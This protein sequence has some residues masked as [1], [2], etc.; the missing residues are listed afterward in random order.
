MTQPLLK[1]F[2]IDQTRMN[3]W[4]S[5]KN[6][7]SSELQLCLQLMN[8]VTL[9]EQAYYDL[10]SAK[11]NVRVQE[12]ALELANRLLAEN[13][14]RVEVG[15]MAPLDEKQAESRVA[16]TRAQLLMAQQ[17]LAAQENVLKKLLHDNFSDW[18][19]V[20]IE[21]TASLAAIPQVFSLQ[22]SWH[23][24]MTLRPDML[25][26]RV[27]LEKQDIVLRYNRNQLFPELD[28]VGSYGHMG[29][30][31][32]QYSGIFGQI[33]EGSSPFYSY[34]AVLRIPLSNRGPRYNY[35]VSKAQ[36][37]QLLLRLKKLEQDILVQIDDAVKRAQT[38][39][40][41]VDSTKQARLY[42][43]AALEAE[44]KK[45]ENGKSTSFFVLQLQ[46]DL[47]AARSAEIGALADYNKSL[48][49]LAL[50]EGATL[51]RHRLQVG[52]K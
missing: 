10:I 5:K 52:V 35:K 4:V 31:V 40:E 44:Q 6:L 13:K 20:A 2:W 26:S 19:K 47:T 9:V 32:S 39:L 29:G 43:E 46:S 27:E 41:R 12:K 14:K 42:A 33:E 23:K 49:Q 22:D 15:A 8:T 48:A 21:P 1:N 38:S 16:S 36:K 11:E 50:A 37:Q 3:I 30:G 25:Q 34:G 45:L 51:E 7:K 24:G 18:H 17:T 28:L